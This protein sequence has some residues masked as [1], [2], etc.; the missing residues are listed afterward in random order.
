MAARTHNFVC[1]SCGA[2]S[3]RWTGRC[4]ACGAWNTLVEEGAAASARSSRKGRLF[5]V[6]SLKGETHEAPRLPCGIAE[7]DRVAGGG[8]VR[9]SVLLLG[10]DPG[11]GKS[12]LL[13]EVAAS[14]ARQRHRAVYISGEEAVAQVRLRAD[15]LG[16][17][18]AAV[19][20]AAETSVEDIV[21]TL[22]QGAIP[23]LLVIDSIQ[24]MWTQTVDAAPGT[25]TQVRGSAGELIRFAKRTGAAVILVG[26]VTKD[27]QIAGPRVVEHM[28]DAVLS[29]EGEGSQQFRILR[30]IKNRFGPT[31]EIGVFEMT[32][33]GLREVANPS[34]LFLSER[35]LGSPGT[36]VF[37]GIEG[38]RPLLVEIQALVA[39]TALG[40]PRRAVV[41]WDPNRLSMV[42]AV[43]EAHC[44]V[45]LSGHDVYLNVAGGLRIQEPAADLAAAAALVSS[46]ARAPLPP[47]AVYFGEVSLSGAV[48]PVAQ[49]AARLKEAQKL[50]F[51]RAIVPEAAR[52]ET[53]EPGLS[54]VAVGAL[55]NLVSEIAARG[56][57]S[58][59]LERDR[60][61]AAK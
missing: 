48:R 60:G 10:G 28:V 7:F 54:L 42:L 34:E 43:L 14:F 18:D 23:R 44:G 51:A 26:H 20:V 58:H 25:V 53:S 16:L 57:K 37:A 30:A 4:D 1:Q 40:T 22:S 59:R 52:A 35:E 45:R 24:T 49:T 15:R 33:T 8:L 39:P 13:V 56:D 19:E 47:D 21:T 3:A 46:L 5:A 50:G 41:G 61:V 12:T 11:I 36:A 29:F 9:G 55:V 27:G 31:D 6:E 2:A 17:G 38:T 32:G